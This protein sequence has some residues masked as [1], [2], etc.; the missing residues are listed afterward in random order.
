MAV[1]LGEMLISGR[2]EPCLE[3]G[4]DI[5]EIKGN[6]PLHKKL[7]FCIQWIYLR[8]S[9]LLLAGVRLISLFLFLT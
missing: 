7:F 4:T 1:A 8:I 3:A 5:Q 6:L 9:S 2:K